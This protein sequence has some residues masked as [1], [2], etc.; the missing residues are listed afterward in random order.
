MKIRGE[1]ESKCSGLTQKGSHCK[2]YDINNGFC[3]IND[4]GPAKVYQFG[5]Q[6]IT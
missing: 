5:R 4:N 1:M 3:K 6:C 2:R